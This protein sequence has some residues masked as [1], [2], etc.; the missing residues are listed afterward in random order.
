MT[1]FETIIEACKP[2]VAKLCA[3]AKRYAML[4]GAASKKV[5]GN[6]S[7][8]LVTL[9]DT[10]W[11]KATDT[12][13][14]K[15]ISQACVMA[16]T[17]LVFL[18]WQLLAYSL[19]QTIFVSVNIIFFAFLLLFI[20]ISI[21]RTEHKM[22]KLNAAIDDTIAAR[23]KKDQEVAQLKT[24]LLDL[25]MA[26]RKQAT[27]GKNSQQL[28]DAVRRNHA[29]QREEEMHG[30]FLLR[31]LAQCYQI[32]GGVVYMLNEETGQ[33]ELAGEYALSTVPVKTVVTEDD[34]M[35]GQVIREG[36]AM[37]FNGVSVDY[38]TVVSGLGS[39]SE[40]N[41]YILPVSR[42]A[43]IVAI[44]EITSFSRLAI[45]DVWKD[46]ESFILSEL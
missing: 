39:A 9:F 5:A 37:A 43:K 35:I 7:T 33:F 26:S 32:C 30:Q 17:M 12:D 6:V 13:K 23:K 29:A 2:S 24:E 1:I 34:G 3:D 10:L 46:V 22:K 38:L 25:K 36:K 42:D 27:F 44:I 15:R 11:A 19:P 4:V 28:I 18:L 16:F 14:A 31:S 21:I 45:V 41:L 20:C 8:K 40:A